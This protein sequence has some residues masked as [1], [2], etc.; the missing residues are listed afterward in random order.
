[1]RLKWGES[2]EER[3]A[4]QAREKNKSRAVQEVHE[5]RQ[6]IEDDLKKME[7]SLQ[8]KKKKKQDDQKQMP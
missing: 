3:L 8:G 6:Y 7:E 4:R 2:R 5:K 1:M